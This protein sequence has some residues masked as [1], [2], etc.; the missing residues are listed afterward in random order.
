LDIPPFPT[1]KFQTLK[2]IASIRKSLTGWI[3][4]PKAIKNIATVIWFIITLFTTFY[5]ENTSILLPSP[6]SAFF[7]DRVGL[8]LILMVCPVPDYEASE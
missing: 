3:R 5:L 6:Q 4:F 2:E 1:R 8:R 7:R